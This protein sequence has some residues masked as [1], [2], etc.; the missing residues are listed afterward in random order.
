MSV[1]AVKFDLISKTPDAYAEAIS[2]WLRSQEE[3]PDAALLIMLLPDGTV[4]MRV[5]ASSPFNNLETLGLLDRT[6]HM[7]LVNL[8]GDVTEVSGA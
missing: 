2:A 5:E 3:T 6:R 1:V 7:V 8:C 4:R